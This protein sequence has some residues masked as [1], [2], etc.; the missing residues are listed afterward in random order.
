MSGAAMI[1]QARVHGTSQHI[2]RHYGCRCPE[3]V[4]A[5]RARWR[6]KY[7]PGHQPPSKRRPPYL[8]EIAIER[9]ILGD[10]VPL[11]LPEREVVTAYLTRRGYTARQIAERLDVSFRTVQ[12]YREA[13]RRAA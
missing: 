1:C 5:Q 8:D 12:R 7:L 13:S 9:A 6:R 11:T 3:T 10:P 4:A 2:Y